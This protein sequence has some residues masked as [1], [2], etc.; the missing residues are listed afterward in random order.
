MKQAVLFL[1]LCSAVLFSCSKSDSNVVTKTP[2]PGAWQLVETLSDPGNGSGM[3]QP[4][5]ESLL[6]TFT[7][8]GRI[9]GTAFPQ[10][11]RYVVTS[12]KNIRFI[13]ADSTFINYNYT[14][15][16][17]TLVL[18]GGGCIEVCGLKFKK[19]L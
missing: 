16:N 1:L 9:E 12:D 7:T 15:A 2:L 5:P 18:S 4:A 10:A 11:R 8:D 19:Q 6:L 17:T 13:Y 14:L 3:W